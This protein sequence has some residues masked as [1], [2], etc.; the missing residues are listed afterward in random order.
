MVVRL[1]QKDGKIMVVR[2]ALK[3]GK[4]GGSSD[5]KRWKKWRFV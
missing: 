2:L 1:T 4:D 3:D 5:S